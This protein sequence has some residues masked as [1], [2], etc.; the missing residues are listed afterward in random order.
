ME[1]YP[2]CQTQ[3]LAP[4]IA[5]CLGSGDHVVT[6]RKHFDVAN[7]DARIWDSSMLKNRLLNNKYIL[8]YHESEPEIES[9]ISSYKSKVPGLHSLMSPFN[10][11]SDIFPN[12]I[13]SQKWFSKYTLKLPFVVICVYTLEDKDA[14]QLLGEALLNARTKYFDMGVRFVAVI[15]SSSKDVDADAERTANLRQISGLARLSGLFYLNTAPETLDRDCGVLTST[16]LHNL[17]TSA[18]DFYS[19]I[20]HKV[21][22]RYR[23]YYSFPE[24]EIDTKISL[25]PKFLEIRN[26][27]K[28]AML[29]QLIHPHN[30][31]SSLSTLE[32]AYEHLIDLMR[33]LMPNFAEPSVSQHDAALY[34]QFRNLLDVLA[35]HLIRGYISIE[36]PVAALRKHDAHIANVLDA[37]SLSEVD[38]SMWL[39]IQYQWLAELMVQVPASVLSDLHKIA[40]GKNKNNQKSIAYYGGISFHG[41]FFSRVIT[42]PSLLFLKAAKKLDSV[43]LS[44]SSLTYL[45][46]YP[47]QAG[48]SEYKIRLLEAAKL[49]VQGP[50]SGK[51]K[52]HISFQGLVSLLEWLIGCEYE[53][54]GDYLRAIEHFQ[55]SVEG[56]N[57]PWDIVTGSVTS[58]IVAAV[59]QIDDSQE[60]LRQLAK[61]SLLKSTSKLSLP[62]MQIPESEY[63]V[64]VLGGKF[65]TVDLFVF[66]QNMK[67]EAH[68]FDA[69]TSQF[70][71][72][73]NFDPALL[74]NTFPDSEVKILI[75]KLEV[76]LG[77]RG[78]VTLTSSESSK[79]DLEIL[80]IEL[81]EH[82]F[83]LGDLTKQRILHLQ[84]VVTDSGWYAVNKVDVQVKVVLKS[85]TKAINFLHSESHEFDD[86]EIIHS[87]KIFSKT[88]KL[89]SRLVRVDSRGANRI[90]I[91]P[92]RPDIGMK[93]SFPFAT[94]IVGEA[95]EILFEISHKKT[96]VQSMNFSSVSLQAQT[97]VVENEFEKDDLPVQTNWEQL[98]DDEP[99]PILQEINSDQASFSRSLRMSIRKPPGTLSTQGN[100]RVVLEIQLL[101][102]ESTGVVSIYELETYLLP[103]VV[104]PFGSLLSVS[105][106]CNAKGEL[107]MPNP[108]ILGIDSG[109]PSKDYSMPL[110][111]RTW[112]AD[113]AIDDKLKLI[114]AGDM[115]LLKAHLN[116]K[117]NNA[118]IVV[119]PVEETVTTKDLV[120]Q[121]FVT[122]SKHRFT[123]RNVT[124]VAQA[125][126]EWKRKGTDLVNVYE[127][128]EWELLLPLQDPRI[129]LQVTDIDAQNMRLAYT[130]E[131]PTPRILTFTTT[132]AVDGAAL[133]GTN[134]LFKASRNLL[135]TKQSAFP[136]LP[137]SQYQMVYLGQYQLDEKEQDIQLPHLHVYDV[138]YKVS[139][140]TLPLDDKVISDKLALYIKGT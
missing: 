18:T 117:S 3:Q 80:K 5:L 28:Q 112:R 33:E 12:G 9:T 64:T 30:V 96:Q 51:D 38:Q 26:L 122:K 94:I 15:V 34:K 10:K 136:V 90:M 52:D 134:W 65:L 66:D 126:F 72:N 17:K 129:L 13:L 106:N 133:Q 37:V 69:V 131:N 63:E 77:E 83:K 78:V 21:R 39:S 128:D 130:I 71:F 55:G 114:E 82:S 49:N 140:P 101:V 23:K 75:E 91:L 102:T 29:T 108:F 97:K 89:E 100:L 54:L 46:V 62:Q 22:Q 7:I 59:A 8:R 116:L 68:A 56:Q 43:H 135:P 127:T 123:D 1:F 95:L 32:Q 115:E 139:L 58:K 24:A 42:E 14:D 41:Q 98:K 45:Q 121:L 88:E 74:K 2:S 27:I 35:I 119:E 48:V 118:E 76:H 125:N 105:P 85:P 86:Q 11:A 109:N 44:T 113:I 107:E 120:S 93:M 137:F 57:T 81:G 67:G 60:Y 103:I 92:Y 61:L 84:D 124:V 47:D 73:S 25:D 53:K 111:S 16:L 50:S 87:K 31:E 36:E 6:L 104:E 70:I 40:K 4:V 20:E 99:L 79:E 132:L 19:A 110:P 138:N